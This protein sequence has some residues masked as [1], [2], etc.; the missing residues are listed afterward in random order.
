MREIT[1]KDLMINDLQKMRDWQF[2]VDQQTEE[3]TTLE[4][5]YATI[6]ATDYDKM[7]GGSGDNVQE[8]KM[9]TAIAKRDQKRHELELTKRKIADINRLLD[10]LDEEE[11]AHI[12]GIQANMWTE[13]VAS[14]D[15][16]QHMEL[17]RLAALS[18]VAWSLD[19]RSEYDVFVSRLERSL[20]PIY[21][22][23][24]YNFA[25]YAFKGIEL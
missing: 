21:R 1:F 20:L 22:E 4:E 16:I 14:F 18:E 2:A 13:Y 19:N 12:K 25:D 17:P 6:K 24:G 9:L 15:H 7:P 23:R 10:Q 8:E 5:E 11:R 3:L